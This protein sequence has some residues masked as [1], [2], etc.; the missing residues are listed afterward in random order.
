MYPQVLAHHDG[1]PVDPSLRPFLESVYDQLTQIP[2]D[3]LALKNGLEQL[4]TFLCSPVG[5]THAN[6]VETDRFFFQHDDWSVSWDHLADE[7]TNV[8]SD[9]GG[10]L[11]DAVSAPEIADNFDSLPEQ[12]LA[13]T[14]ALSSTPGAV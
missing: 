12:L 6:C 11:H 3:Y 1:Q 9:I 8:L 5:R 10:L 2:P 14:R 13:R 4:L 7:Y